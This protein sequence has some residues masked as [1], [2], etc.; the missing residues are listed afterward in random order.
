VN[1][2]ISGDLRPRRRPLATAAGAAVALLGVVVLVTACGSSSSDSSATGSP[3]TGSSSS[4]SSSSGSPSSGRGAS[5]ARQ[6][7][8]LKYARCM[9]ANGVPSFPDP[10]ANGRFGGIQRKLA[11]DPGF[12]AAQQA[13]RGLA[14]GGEHQ[15]G[16]PAVVEQLRKFAQCM[17]KN[18]LAQFPDPDANGGFPPGTEQLQ[19]DPNF[20]TALQACFGQLPASIQSH[21]G[22]GG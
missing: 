19:G 7:Q 12:Q 17:R 10:D 6:S 14:P 22:G 9:R 11:G 3:V 20:P 16:S 5:A 1:R 13:C 2:P 15:S 18:G 4:G 21:A 8:A